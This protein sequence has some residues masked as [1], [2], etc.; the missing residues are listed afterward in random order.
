MYFP[1]DARQSQAYRLI[2]PAQP[3]Y[4]ADEEDNAD[5]ELAYSN[6][7][8]FREAHRSFLLFHSLNKAKDDDQTRSPEDK[9]NTRKTSNI[10]TLPPASPVIPP[11]APLP[12]VK[13][14]MII[15][16]P[17]KSPFALVIREQFVPPLSLPQSWK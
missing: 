4:E 12:Q 14:P 3:I 9:S 7:E 10:T 5:Y 17:P 13:A 15:F 6:P 16:D 8:E 1:R 2:T 11:P